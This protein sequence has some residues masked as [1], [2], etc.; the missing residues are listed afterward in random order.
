MIYYTNCKVAP[1]LFE[2]NQ[3]MPTYM[4]VMSMLFHIWIM[5]TFLNKILSIHSTNL[6]K[7]NRDVNIHVNSKT[8]NKTKVMSFSLH[9]L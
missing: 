2:S 4:D 5:N 1:K 7:T 8:P 3:P 9:V 6:D